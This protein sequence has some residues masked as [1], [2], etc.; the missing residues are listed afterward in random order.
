ME[1]MTFK[2]KRDGRGG[3]KR[4]AGSDVFLNCIIFNFH[5]SLLS[6]EAGI[7]LKINGPTDKSDG[8]K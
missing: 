1:R 2:N 3:E 8:P 7:I 5:P 6:A 4:A